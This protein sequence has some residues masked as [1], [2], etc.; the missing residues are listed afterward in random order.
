[1]LKFSKSSKKIIIEKEID[2]NLA[3]EIQSNLIEYEKEDKGSIRI[4]IN[5]NGGSVYPALG[6]TDVMSFVSYPIE[7]ECDG[8]AAGTAALILA[9]GNKGHRY[10][11]KNSRIAIMYAKS[12]EI[13]SLSILDEIH[14]LNLEIISMFAE[15]TNKA[16]HEIKTA[17]ESAGGELWMSAEEAK[18][19]GIIDEIID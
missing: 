18:V 14:K 10:A 5:S 8:I 16:K 2:D 19:F 13:M 3:N 4:V 1:M 11:H 6:I 9:M 12:S 7:T 15:Q 17:I